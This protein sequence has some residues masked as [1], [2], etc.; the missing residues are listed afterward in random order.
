MIRQG[1]PAQHMYFIRSGYVDLIMDKLVVDTLHDGDFFGEDALL[2]LPPPKVLARVGFQ[3]FRAFTL[4]PTPQMLC[5]PCPPRCPCQGG[6]LGIRAQ[7]LGLSPPSSW[8]DWW[9]RGEDLCGEAAL[10]ALPPPDVLA[11]VG[12]AFQGFYPKTCTLDPSS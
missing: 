5:W 3:P 11:R 12:L 2:A 1:W 10:L 9:V 4:N 6:L 8:T 7:E